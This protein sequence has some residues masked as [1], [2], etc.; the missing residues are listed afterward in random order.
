M[1]IILTL[2]LTAFTV[3]LFGLKEVKACSCSGKDSPCAEYKDADLLFVGTVSKI[4]VV[5]DSNGFSNYKAA[6]LVD[7]IFKGTNFKQINV[8]TSTQGTACG[9]DFEDGQK[10]L[11]YG[12]LDKKTNTFETS[13]CTRTRP[14]K[15]GVKD[16]EVEILRSIARGKVE[17]R[18]YGAIYE[19]V[20]GIG[21]HNVEYWTEKERKPLAEVKVIAS[22]DGRTY[23]SITDKDGKFSIKNLEIGKYKISFG[24]PSTHKLGGDFWDTSI[25]ANNDWYNNPEVEIPESSCPDRLIIETRVDGRIKGR[26]FDD[27]GKPVGKDFR[28]SLVT[29]S[30]AKEEVGD[31]DAIPAYTDEGGYYEFYGIPPGRYFLGIN[32]DFKPNKDY[33]YPRT[34]FP[35][36]SD[37]SKA[38]IIVLSKAEKLNG[39]DLYLPLQVTE[40][41]IK[42]KVVGADGKPIKGAIVE[43][44]GLYHGK[45]KET[46]NYGMSSIKQPTFE[47]RVETDSN[48]EF[49]LK[50]LKGN[51]YRLNAYLEKEN[52]YEN[53]LEGEDI[54]I[55]ADENTK[56]VILI[57][58]KKP[59]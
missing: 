49:S 44:Y 52:S 47:G 8:Q 12:Y 43:R 5:K 48:G 21:T 4:T 45:L 53:I 42:G 23:E 37:I 32:L 57:L 56:P 9:Y 29:E 14:L 54:D 25:K 58:N 51:K 7:E 27:Q 33:P 19:I 15:F 59:K 36:E 24:I 17:P 46:D 16:D 22:K 31:I 10:Y 6:F 3:I 13:I 2:L 39:I 34:Y 50:L 41:E 35:N 18:I 1:K 40:I 28:I 11:V 20:R 30:S 55:E 38:K 26:L